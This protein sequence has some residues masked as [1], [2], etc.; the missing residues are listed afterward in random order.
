MLNNSHPSPKP[1]TPSFAI[2]SIATAMKAVALLKTATGERHDELP[3]AE[4]RLDANPRA[5]GALEG[6][7]VSHKIGSHRWLRKW[8]RP[9]RGHSQGPVCGDH[10]QAGVHARPRRATLHAWSILAFAR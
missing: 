1:G 9:Y 5:E 8:P 4:F 10:V 7:A 6:A 3:V 2:A